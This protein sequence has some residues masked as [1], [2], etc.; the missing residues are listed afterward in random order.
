MMAQKGI[1][2]GK[3]KKSELNDFMKKCE[4]G[5]ND[6]KRIVPDGDGSYVYFTFHSHGEVDAE[7]LFEYF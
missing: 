5:P 7:I 2:P 4:V 1:K 3:I 6:R